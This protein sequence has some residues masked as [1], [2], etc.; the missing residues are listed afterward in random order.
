MIIWEVEVL[1]GE[2]GREH[3]NIVN[4]RERRQGGWQN[5][6]KLPSIEPYDQGGWTLE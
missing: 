1:G 2:G 3:Q 6:N 4:K 5:A